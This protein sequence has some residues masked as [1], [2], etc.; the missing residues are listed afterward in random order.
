MSGVAIA[1]RCWPASPPAVKV[2]H[3]GARLRGVLAGQ[4]AVRFHARVHPRRT[5]G[6]SRPDDDR[7]RRMLAG[8]RLH[9]R[10]TA[11]G[12]FGAAGDDDEV[13]DAGPRRDASTRLALDVGRQIVARPDPRQLALDLGDAVRP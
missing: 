10:G 6:I 3:L 5:V 12:E 8:Q 1:A 13:H 11:L 9:R 4:D 2:D 7:A